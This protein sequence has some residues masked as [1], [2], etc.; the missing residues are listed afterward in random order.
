MADAKL[1]KIDPVENVI[2]M[3]KEYFRE[4]DNYS[5]NTEAEKFSALQLA[6]K[7]LTPEERIRFEMRVLQEEVLEY[8]ECEESRK[9]C[10]LKEYQYEVDRLTDEVKKA[11]DALKLHKE[12][13]IK[14]QL[15]YQT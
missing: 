15:Q 10:R 7:S 13:I 1:I 6:S 2:T 3:R 5:Y 12:K 14:S 11:Q 4:R 9:S 8:L